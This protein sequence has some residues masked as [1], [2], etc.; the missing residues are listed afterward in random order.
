V[1]PPSSVTTLV[2]EER[3]KGTVF[4]RCCQMGDTSHLFAAGEPV[5]HAGLFP[6]IFPES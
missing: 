2:T 3:L 1:L 6:E 4:F 5:S